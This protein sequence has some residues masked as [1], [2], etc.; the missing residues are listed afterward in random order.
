V[1]EAPVP[2][3]R[4]L[5]AWRALCEHLDGR[6]HKAEYPDSRWVDD[7]RRSIRTFTSAPSE[8]HEA[9]ASLIGPGKDAVAARREFRLIWWCSGY[10]WKLHSGWRDR[11]AELEAAAG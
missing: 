8:R 5:A 10:G 2:S 9:F 11:L 7:G 6:K 4:D 1:A 3:P